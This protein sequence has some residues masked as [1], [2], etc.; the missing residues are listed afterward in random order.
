MASTVDVKLLSQVTL[1]FLRELDLT[2]AT[3]AGEESVHG[4]WGVQGLYWGLQEILNTYRD[5]INNVTSGHRVYNNSL[6]HKTLSY[7]NRSLFPKHYCC[8]I[9]IIEL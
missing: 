8:S 9:G 6:Y 3:F 1:Y 2:K 5:S 4:L 7:F